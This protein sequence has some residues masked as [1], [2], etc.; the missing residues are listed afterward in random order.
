LGHGVKVLDAAFAYSGLGFAVLPLLPCEKRPHTRLIEATRGSSSWKVLGERPASDDEIRVWYRRDPK[1]NLGIITG[2]ASGG[3][4]VADFDDRRPERLIDTPTV[5]TGRGLHVYL[6]SREQIRSRMGNGLELKAEGGY[7]VAPP[8]VHPSG[9]RYQWLISLPGLRHVSEAN[10]APFESWELIMPLAEKRDSSLVVPR[11]LSL[12]D[13]PTRVPTEVPTRFKRGKLGFLESFDADPQAVAAMCRALRIPYGD[14]TAFRCLLHEDENPSASV[15][16]LEDGTYHYH[17]WHA[18]PEW[19]TF[20]Q[21]RAALAGRPRARGPEL[22]TWKLILL[23]EAGVLP[24]RPLMPMPVPAQASERARQVYDRFMFV[25][26]CRWNYTHGEPMP[27]SQRF[28]A[29]LTGLSPSQVW[30]ATRELERLGLLERVG[31]TGTG[32]QQAFLWLPRGVRELGAGSGVS[33][34]EARRQQPAE[35]VS[36]PISTR[37]GTSTHAS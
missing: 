29:A 16:Q 32:R 35:R 26:G 1:A 36:M 21:V 8:S 7:V 24:A 22:A 34:E 13:V 11:D 15:F 17:D 3:L 4:V 37:R 30:W 14:G 20:A 25:L 9:Q 2:R 12:L 19:R 27:F 28:G 23:A 31:T 10:L 5:Q 33:L 18:Y 6:R